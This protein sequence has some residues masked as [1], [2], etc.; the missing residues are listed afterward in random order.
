M[1]KILVVDDEASILETLDMF[2]GESGHTVLK[3][4]TATQ[5]LAMF[6]QHVPEVVILDIRLPD[7]NGLDVLSEIRARRRD[8][9]VIMITAYQDMETTIEAMKRG[10]YDYIH[11]PLDIGE[12]EEAIGRALK[13]LEADQKASTP[14]FSSHA[15]EKDT[16]VGR[17][18]KMREIFKT[19]GLLCQNRVSVLIEGE[20]GTG[21]ELIARVIHRKSS[22]AREPFVILDCSATVETLLET[23]LFGHEKG[24]FTGAVTAKRGKIELAGNGTLFLDEVGELPLGVQKKLLGFLQRREYTRVGGQ[25][26]LRSGCRIIAATH[27]ELDEMV[28]DGLFREDLYYRLKVVSI[29]VPPLRDR[30]EDIPALVSHFLN[31][32]NKDLGT[33]VYGLQPGAMEVL[34]AYSWPGNVRELENVLVEGIVRA[35]GNVI[36]LEDIKRILN[37]RDTY[38]K[39]QQDNDSLKTIEK[40]HIA[41]VLSEVRWNRTEAAKR[42]GISLPTLRRKIRIYGLEP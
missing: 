31:R 36:L 13:V 8:A 23:E 33:S 30:K 41:A 5:G 40:E 22:N 21:K 28:G 26:T 15:P 37:R 9:K 10:G 35:R 7:A 32:I 38:P 6:D 42:L 4:D 12:I 34:Q 20:T 16:I 2:L 3:A 18:P 25:N 29:R 1:A 24:A 14:G 11:K 27:R 39:A 19:I 17:S